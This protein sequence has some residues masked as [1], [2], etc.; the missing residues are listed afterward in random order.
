VNGALNAQRPLV[1]VGNTQ[2]DDGMAVRL[3]EPSK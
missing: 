2:L 3:A 1:V